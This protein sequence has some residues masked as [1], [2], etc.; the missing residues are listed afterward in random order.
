MKRHHDLNHLTGI[1]IKKIK[2]KI[3][4]YCLLKINVTLQ[5][6][7]C[8]TTRAKLGYKLCIPNHMAVELANDHLSNHLIIK[9]MLPHGLGN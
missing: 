4:S 1:T 8:H 6:L 3:T 2:I 7:V 5:Y 9:E